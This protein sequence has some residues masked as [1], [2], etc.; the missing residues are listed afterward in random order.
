MP[1]TNAA[2][3]CAVDPSSSTLQQAAPDEAPAQRRIMLRRKLYALLTLALAGGMLSGLLIARIDRNLWLV[4]AAAFGIVLIC[5]VDAGRRAIVQPLDDLLHRIER[6]QLGGH[7][8]ALRRLPVRRDDEIGR[9]ARAVHGLCLGQIRNRREADT[10]RRTFDDRVQR[11]TRAATSQLRQLVQRDPLTN[12]GNRRFMQEQLPQLFEAVRQA[13]QPMA[14]VAIDI[15]NF[16][17]I[18]DQRG[19]AIGDAV[20]LQLATLLRAAARESDI[21]VRLGGDEFALWLP[22]TDCNGAAVLAENLRKLF[23]QQVRLISSSTDA[24]LDTALSIGLADTQRDQVGS[25]EQLLDL[26]DQRLYTAKHN[27][28]DC[29]HDGVGTSAA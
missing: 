17:Q 11:A 15:D 9:L 2:D 6:L 26:A 19:H 1:Q 13:H 10:L 24:P 18:N 8:Q 16:K 23:T 29:I 27:G 25:A 12:L 4:L 21:A 28:K 5:L 3:S 14:C 7:R 20:L 22:G